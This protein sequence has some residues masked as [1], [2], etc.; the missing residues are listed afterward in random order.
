MN[1]GAFIHELSIQYFTIVYT[2]GLHDEHNQLVKVLYIAI[3]LKLFASCLF[4]I[5]ECLKIM[6]CLVQSSCVESKFFLLLS[7]HVI[8]AVATL[9][10]FNA[11]IMQARNTVI[12]CSQ[13][14]LFSVLMEYHMEYKE[15]NFLTRNR[16]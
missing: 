5:G 9:K 7:P 4:F 16:G 12:T 14:I 10:W 3:V 2:T 11:W 8:S 13:S 1:K 6:N 15:H